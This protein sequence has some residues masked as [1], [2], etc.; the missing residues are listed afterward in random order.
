[1]K[2]YWYWLVTIEDMWFD[3]IRKLMGIFGSPKEVYYADE[4]ILLESGVLSLS[5]IIKIQKSKNRDIDKEII[6]LSEKKI[7][8][9]SVD[10]AEYPQKLLLYGDRPYVLFYKGKIPGDRKLVAVVGARNCSAYGKSISDK[11]SYDLSQQGISVISGMARGV[12]KYSHIGCI[13]GGT[14]TYAVLGCGVD[15]CYPTENIEVYTNI[16]ENGGILSEYPPGAAA[17]AWRFPY[18]NRIISMFADAVLVVEAK[19]RSGTLITVDYA[20]S[21]GKE[22]FAVPGRVNDVLSMGCNKLIKAG[23]FPC[24]DAE[25]IL[26]YLGIDNSKKTTKNNFI[27]EKDFEVVY[28]LLCLHPVGVEELVFKTGLNIGRVYEILMKLRLNGMAEEVCNGHYI[29]K[30]Q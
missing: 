3:K 10:D 6:D 16:L 21:Y 13:K 11:I 15:I 7:K 9:V 23:A 22:V 25:D 30:L 12:D 20:L 28:S 8:I 19:E 17:L 24:T 4:K 18:R 2:K 26:M 5:D 14:E 29:K 27:L 1:M